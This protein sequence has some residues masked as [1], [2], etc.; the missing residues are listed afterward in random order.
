MAK[1]DEIK[2]HIGALKSYLNII[3][4][5]LLAVGAGIAKLYIDNNIGL[6]FWLGSLLVI[7]VLIVFIAISKSMHRHIKKLKDLP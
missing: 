1:V 5:V 4:A 3:V 2:E 7:I 6:L